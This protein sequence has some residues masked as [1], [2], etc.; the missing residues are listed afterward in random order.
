MK[1]FDLPPSRIVGEIKNA[2]REAVL[3]GLIPNEY[4]AAFEFMIKIAADLGI[5]KKV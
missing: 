4:N 2:V 1:E 5:T 3:D